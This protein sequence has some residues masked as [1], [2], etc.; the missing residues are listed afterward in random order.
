VPTVLIP[1]PG[2][3][4]GYTAGM[5][6]GVLAVDVALLLP[7]PAEARA[8]A[9]NRA[10]FESDP[11][12]F[13]FDETHLPHLTL[14]QQ[15]VRAA[16]LQRAIRAIE[17]VALATRAGELEVAGIALPR[18]TSHLVIASAAWLTALH[19][20]LLDALGPFSAD[21]SLESF[22]DG[23]EPAREADL[24]WASSY[25]IAAS[26]ERFNPHVTLGVGGRPDPGVR[27]RFTP[28]RLALCQLGR[29]CT[30]RRLLEA[31]SLP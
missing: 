1:D 16:E 4:T 30:C 9:F 11:S 22:V 26:R 3:G 28:E 23:A 21:L 27:F 19:E 8:V 31:W 29:Y 2:T 18:H 25:R 20:A 14:V 12:G 7:E 24:E 17:A 15:G 5:Q 10:L 13:L 6:A